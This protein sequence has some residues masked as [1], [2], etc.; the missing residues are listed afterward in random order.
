MKLTK[1]ALA[2]ALLVPFV[3][4]S[5]STK[6]GNAVAGAAAYKVYDDHKDEQKREDAAKYKY[7][8]NNKNHKNHNRR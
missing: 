7:Y 3:F 6:A 8:K 1:V 5:C 4:A 2:V